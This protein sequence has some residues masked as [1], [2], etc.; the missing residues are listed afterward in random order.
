MGHVYQAVGWNRQKKRYDEVLWSGILLY[1]T[2]FVGGGL[3]W[4][5]SST[6][7]TLLIRSTSS[8]AFLLLHIT[9]SI[10][11]LSR[12]H[13]G[14]LPLL[15]NR[16]HLG[17]SM[18][19]IALSHAVLSIVQFHAMGDINPILSVFVNDR[20]SDWRMGIPFQ[21]LG[22][23]GL[24]ILFLMAATSHDFWLN[25]LTAPV[26]KSLHMLVYLAYGLIFGHI[27]FGIAQDSTSAI[28]LI[29]AVAG[30]GWLVCLHLVAGFREKRLD[31][32]G[33]SVDGF[34]RVCSVEEIKPD[35]A[36]TTLVSGERV[37]VFRSD[38]GITAISG[39]C[40]HQNGPLGEGRIIDGFV[41]CPWHGYQYCP[42][43][44]KS[45]EPFTESV[46]TFRTS[47]IDGQVYVSEIPDP[48]ERHS[49]AS[50]SGESKYE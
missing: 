50:H 4:F 43:T 47:I 48:E 25:Q 28:P 41:T 24:I 12:L 5:P 20:V 8:L 15:Y 39:V 49:P 26:W 3:L 6:I 14:F 33:L 37:A 45:P 9:L 40:Q 16:R 29:L 2:I 11:P 35:R 13:P 19:A 44:G 23:L 17:V 21:P 32:P 1:L 46:P 38:H 7:E 18:F 36:V 31:T 42:L 22:L 27:I 30:A 34:V 10:G